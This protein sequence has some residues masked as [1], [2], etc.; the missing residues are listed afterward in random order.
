MPSPTVSYDGSGTTASKSHGVDGDEEG[1]TPTPTIDCGNSEMTTTTP[2]GDAEGGEAAPVLELGVCI[3]AKLLSH[4]GANKLLFASP[5]REAVLCD[6][7][8]SCD[9]AGHM[10]VHQGSLKMICS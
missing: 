5:R 4:L 6:S 7:T 2:G 10:V 1:G 8:G 9:T 3:D